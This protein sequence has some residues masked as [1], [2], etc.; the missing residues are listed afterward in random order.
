M[1]TAAQNDLTCGGGRVIVAGAGVGVRAE[2]EGDGNPRG[3]RGWQPKRWK[4]MATKEVEGDGNHRVTA[5]LPSAGL[6]SF[7]L[8]VAGLVNVEPCFPHACSSLSRPA[9]DA[10][11][12]PRLVTLAH[13]RGEPAGWTTAWLGSAVVTVVAGD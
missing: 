12:R 6:G 8:Q 9:P 10:S 7:S 2:V 3:E 4:G 1:R 5:C 11:T 13:A